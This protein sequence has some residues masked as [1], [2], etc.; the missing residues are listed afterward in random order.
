MRYAETKSLNELI[1]ALDNLYVGVTTSILHT[2]TAVLT[3]FGRSTLIR[4]GNALIKS[5]TVDFEK[6]MSDYEFFQRDI[7]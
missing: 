2:E 4:V 7:P 6:E 1:K 3:P 5:A